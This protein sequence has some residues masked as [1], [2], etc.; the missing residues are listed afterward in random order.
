MQPS[1]QQVLNLVKS[2]SY[3]AVSSQD[4]DTPINTIYIKGKIFDIEIKN[5][6]QNS[7]CYQLSIDSNFENTNFVYN[8]KNPITKKVIGKDFENQ[9]AT[10]IKEKNFVLSLDENSEL[11]VKTGEIN[12]NTG[13]LIWG[14]WE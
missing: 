4:F 11:I 6:N 9:I 7:E 13:E 10:F 12:K 14:N 5:W 1:I 8:L 3:D 2:L